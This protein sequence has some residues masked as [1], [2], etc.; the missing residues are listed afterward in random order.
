MTGPLGSSLLPIPWAYI[1]GVQPGTLSPLYRMYPR[2]RALL[3]AFLEFVVLPVSLESILPAAS[4]L[5][6]HP[7]PC[8]PCVIPTTCIPGVYFIG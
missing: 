1:P 5:G 4:V 8:I 2:S 7:T 3:P 6:V